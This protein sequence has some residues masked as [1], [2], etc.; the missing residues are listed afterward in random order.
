MGVGADT[1]G[2]LTRVGAEVPTD[3]AGGFVLGPVLP[4]RYTLRV[5]AMQ[6]VLVERPLEVRAGVVDTVWITMRYL[7]CVGY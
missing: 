6:H 5:R 3:S 7:R 4:G 1:A 2:A